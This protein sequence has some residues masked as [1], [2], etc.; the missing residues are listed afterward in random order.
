[1]EMHKA[2]PKVNSVRNNGPEMLDK[3]D[4]LAQPGELPL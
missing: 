4:L 3:V 2:N 1:M